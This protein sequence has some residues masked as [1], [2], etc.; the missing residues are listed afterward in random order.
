MADES[1]GTSRDLAR[2]QGRFAVVNVK[3]DKAGGLTEAIHMARAAQASGMKSYVGNMFGTSLAM[4][5]AF[6]LGQI[7][8]FVE[9]DGPLF[10]M[11]DRADPLTLNHDI[12]DLNPRLWGWP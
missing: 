9:L 12:L 5:P 3:L 11:A 2:L 1:A 4:A 7:C 6:L 8:D 10:L